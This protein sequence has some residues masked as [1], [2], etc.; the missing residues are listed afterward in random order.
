MVIVMVMCVSVLLADDLVPVV[1]GM[2][3]DS[4]MQTIVGIVS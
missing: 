4:M 2:D 3:Q 1:H